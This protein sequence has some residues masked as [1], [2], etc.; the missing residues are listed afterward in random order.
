[1]Q[2]IYHFIF[3][4]TIDQHHSCISFDSVAFEGLWVEKGDFAQ[5]RPR[6]GPL[7]VLKDNGHVSGVVI[8]AQALNTPFII[9]R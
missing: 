8:F 4:L 9:L 3:F 2:S 6:V 5:V 1:M 7:D